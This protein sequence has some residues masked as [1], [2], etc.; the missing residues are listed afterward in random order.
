MTGWEAGKTK[1]RKT[2]LKALAVVQVG[3]F[4]GLEQGN[5]RDEKQWTN[6]RYFGEDVT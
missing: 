1:S 4:R 2:N 6:L 5:G 3:S